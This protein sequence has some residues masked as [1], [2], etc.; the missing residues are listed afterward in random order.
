A[1][2]LDYVVFTATRA[3]ANSFVRLGIPIFPVAPAD[4]ARLHDGEDGW[5]TY[6]RNSPTVMVGRI[7]SGLHTVGEQ[8]A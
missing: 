1:R 7:V 6:Y 3:L 4:P 8:A 2:G 5:G